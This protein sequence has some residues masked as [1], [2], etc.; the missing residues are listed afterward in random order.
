MSIAYRS[1]GE[2]EP[3]RE[4]NVTYLSERARLLSIQAKAAAR[5]AKVWAYIAV[6]V[7]VVNVLYQAIYLCLKYG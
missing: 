7:N 3:D 6:V 5:S 4:S 2:V 1:P